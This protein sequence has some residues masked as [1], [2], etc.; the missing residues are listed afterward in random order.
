MVE[1]IMNENIMNHVKTLNN[2]L[3]PQ[4]LDLLQFLL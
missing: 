1:V 2:I 3:F 4:F